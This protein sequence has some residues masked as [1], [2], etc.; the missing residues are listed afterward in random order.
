MQTVTA[1]FQTIHKY[2][3]QSKRGQ[4]AIPQGLSEMHVPLFRYVLAPDRD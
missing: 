4:S 1:L 2:K 3:E